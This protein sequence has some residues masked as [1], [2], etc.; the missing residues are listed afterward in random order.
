[1]DAS[2]DYLGLLSLYKRAEDLLHTLGVDTAVD[3]SAV[4]ELRYAG[5]HTLNALAA[6]ANCDAD[7]EEN[8]SRVPRHTA[9]GQFTTPTMQPFSTT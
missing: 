3:T 9:N 2:G 6:V 1:M 5:R 8:K 4:N 7:E